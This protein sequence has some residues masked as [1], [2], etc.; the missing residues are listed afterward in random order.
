MLE[1]TS[2][3]EEERDRRAAETDVRI[4]ATTRAGV[5]SAVFVVGLV[6]AAL[7][8]FGA[9]DKGGT[10]ELQ[11]IE[12]QVKEKKRDLKRA[13]RKERSV[14]A[15]LEKLDRSIY[16]GATELAENRRHLR[17]VEATL[18]EIEKNNTALSRDLADIERIYGRRVRALYKMGRNSYAVAILTS[19]SFNT[20]LKRLKYLGVIAERDRTIMKSYS[21]ALS[22]MAARQAEITGKKEEIFNRKRAVEIKKAELEARRHNKAGI[23]S[24]IRSEKSVYEQTLRELEESSAS[25]WAMIKKAEEEKKPVRNEPS[26]SDAGARGKARLPW[27]VRGQ[28]LTPFGM[29]RHPQF[30]T[31]VFRRGIEIGAH[32]GDTVRAIG[33]G[34]VAYA[35]W[36]KGY[37]KLLIIEHKPGFYALYGNLSQMDIAKGDKVS[38][39]QA[40]GLVGDTGSLKGPKLYFEIRYKGEAQDPQL[41][42]EKR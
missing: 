32:E 39:G 42:L 14:L 38:K 21:A 12:R 8:V 11:R 19:D 2:P 34:Q 31:M 35:D 20:A 27:P 10:K 5:L 28:V 25:L 4:Q 13:S 18:R 9:D 17:E 30:K 3:H 33:D 23:L 6:L 36:Y 16:A 41:W 24:S 37:G 40:V 1:K 22:R 7:P 15:E 29:Q 26:G